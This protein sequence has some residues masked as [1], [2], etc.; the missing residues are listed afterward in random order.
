ML[1]DGT[2]EVMTRNFLR[3]KG[4]NEIWTDLKGLDAA[5]EARVLVNRMT[6]QEWQLTQRRMV[7]FLPVHPLLRFAVFRQVAI[8]KDWKFSTQDNYWG[9]ALSAMRNLNITP[10]EH[11]RRAARWLQA[12]ALKEIPA[13]APP[14]MWSH[15]EKLARTYPD[16]QVTLVI[17][18]AFMLGQRLPDMALLRKSRIQW[19]ETVAITLVEGKVIPRIGPF[20][21][22]LV[23][24]EQFHVAH[25]L[26]KHWERAQDDRLFSDTVVHQAALRLKGL[27]QGLEVRS[28]RRGGLQAMALA[29]VPTAVILKFSRHASEA[30]LRKYLDH[31]NCMVHDQEELA[32]AQ[33]QTITWWAN[34]CK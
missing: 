7:V 5:F 32:A 28:P 27:A 16:D 21:I 20:T 23:R 15:A 11:E 17:L 31:G 4:F 12:Q 30:M 19:R 9:A 2:F 33:Q 3:A 26:R 34:A 29:G 1:E 13:A 10:Q 25:R 24:Y 18:L 8:I 14:M 6:T 22:V